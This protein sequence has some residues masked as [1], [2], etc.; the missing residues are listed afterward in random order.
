MTELATAPAETEADGRHDFDFLFGD[1]RLA[2][3]KLR[4]PLA[5][6]PAEWQEFE[7]TA[8]AAPIL[9]GLGNYDSLSV[10][11]FP[12]RPGFYGFSLRL[13]DVETGEW[14]I[15]WSSTSA[16]GQ[17]DTPVVGR[18]RDGEGRFECDDVF[19]ERAVRVRYDWTDITPSSARWT[20]SFSFDSGAT[21][22]PNWFMELTRLA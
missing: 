13:F 10:P 3:R 14:R 15:W 21:F 6:G 4:D 19:G 22:E 16:R 17:L 7:A 1:W 9:G 2:N 12:D 18:F 11:D 5:D 8:H 20:Q